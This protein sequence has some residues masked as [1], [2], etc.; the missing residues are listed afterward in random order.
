MRTLIQKFKKNRR[1]ANHV[2]F[3][4]LKIAELNGE[5]IKEVLNKNN[6]NNKAK[7]LKKYNRRLKL[8]VY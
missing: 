1:K 2:K 4:H 8:I 3:L 7:L 6:P 5:I